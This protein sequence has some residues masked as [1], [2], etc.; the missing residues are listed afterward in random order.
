MAFA[1]SQYSVPFSYG[2]WALGDRGSISGRRSAVFSAQS[3][4]HHHQTAQRWHLDTFKVLA[5][6]RAMFQKRLAMT[7]AE[8]IKD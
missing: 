8:R 1:Q 6:Q 2:F 3:G 4:R 5:Q 7:P